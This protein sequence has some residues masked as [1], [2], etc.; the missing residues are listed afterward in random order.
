MNFFDELIIPPSENHVML[1]KYMLTI[2][3][4]LFIPYI[5]MMLGA[6]FI[7]THF[8]KKGKI[9]GNSLYLR[10]A[11]DIIEKLTITK[12]AEL[13]LGTIPAIS[14]FFAY[15]QLLYTAKTI[16]VGML[17]LA[18]IL[19]ILSFVFIYKYRSTF[20]LEG[21]MNAF[22]SISSKDALNSEN[23]RT[24]EI[25]DFEEN[26]ISTNSTAGAAGKWLLLAASYIFAGT[27]ALAS[28]PDKWE[29]VGNI[30]QIIFSWQTLFSWGALVSL[31]G[32]ITGGAIMF[33]FFSWDGGLKD[34]DDAYASLVK[35]TAGKIALA[36]GILFPLMLM[37]SYSYL[38]QISQSP[39]VFYY[40]VI[41]L[42]ISLVAGNFIYSMFKNSDTG[43][44]TVVF[45]LVFV[46]VTFNIIKDQIAF[47]NAIHEN[48]IEITKL[49]AEEEKEV[50]GRTMQ[51][52][53]IDA[54]SIFNQKCSAC[55]KF[56][57]KLVGPPYQ[58][59]VPKYNGDVQKLADFIFNPQKIDPAFPPMPNQGLKKKEANAMAQWLIDKV[60][61]K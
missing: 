58:Q 28:S 60:G 18:V 32:I 51:T 56:D 17:A 41:V 9:E 45:I 5:S 36:S 50:K 8:N 4:L 25:K 43:S 52:S 42:I 35:N 33:Y 38:P 57:Q 39:T 20:K 29:H 12:S 30:L 10:F 24:K 7:S 37:I 34:M 31:S 47:G 44:A 19:F 61:K 15:A 2:S 16:S 14:T 59:T 27:M 22:K 48:T 6:T 55:H 23:E 46:L 21:V 54:Q 11:K 26:I 49:A 40:M 13:A 1:L 3:L 53:G